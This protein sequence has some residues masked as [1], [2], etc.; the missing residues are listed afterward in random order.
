[1]KCIVI[2]IFSPYTPHLLLTKWINSYSMLFNRDTKNNINSTPRERG[3]LST[4]CKLRA[5]VPLPD[6][7]ESSAYLSWTTWVFFFQLARFLTEIIKIVIPKR[8][9]KNSLVPRSNATT[10]GLPC[11]GR[12]VDTLLAPVRWQ[13]CC[14]FVGAQQA[15][16]RRM[17]W[18]T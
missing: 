9:S 18:R 3:R 4:R 2:V 15:Y 17:H 6:Q 1:M 10:G 12:T 7:R 11:Y 14:H 5:V 16:C 8:T 13:A